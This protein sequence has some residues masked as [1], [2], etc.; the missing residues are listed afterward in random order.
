MGPRPDGNRS[1]I[2]GNTVDSGLAPSYRELD[3]FKAACLPEGLE[4]VTA[5]E[6]EDSFDAF[7]AKQAAALLLA[8]RYDGMDLPDEA[9]RLIVLTG[10]PART[11]LQERFFL[12]RLGARRVLS[13]RI[14]TRLVQGAGRCTRNSRDFAAVI[15]R[16][17]GLT[18]FSSREEEIR[19][20]RPELQAEMRFGLDNSEQTD[21]DLNSLLED[22]LQQ[23]AAWQVA[24]THLRAETAHAQRADVSDAESL[25]AAASHEVECWR[26]LWRDDLRRAV[27]EAQSA[28]D[29]LS[30]GPGLRPYRALWF[31]FAASWS[32]ELEQTTH[33]SDDRELANTLQSE[34]EGAARTMRWFPQLGADPPAAQPEEWNAR[35]DRAARKLLRLGIRGSKFERHV[36]EALVRIRDDEATRFELG[37]LALGELLGFDA[38]RPNDTSDPDGVWGDDERLRLLFEA[39]TEE[40]AGSPVS[41]SAVRQAQTHPQWVESRLD[42][43]PPERQVTLLVS[44]RTQIHPDA[45]AIAGGV[46]LVTPDAIRAVAGRAVDVHREV[47]AQ[48]R[49]RSEQQLVADFAHRFAHRQL[50]NGGL[51]HQLSPRPITD[52]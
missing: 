49:G 12:D 29:Q 26:A 20:M 27:N 43:P 19:A 34:A 32:R 33:R 31:Y 23:G 46:L 41:T 42:W 10:M 4:A 44:N 51:V 8:N 11:H 24:E 15:I 38:I 17:E 36:S 37:L 40:G 47:R 30:G 21:V 14:R 3:R 48:A 16:G 50:D 2:A 1:L 35:A 13:E 9:C 25:R 5:E 6:V 39:K 22:F 7:V 45:S 52:G 18:D 28:T